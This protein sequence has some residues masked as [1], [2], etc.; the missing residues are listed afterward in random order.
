MNLSADEVDGPDDIRAFFDEIYERGWTDGLPVIP[1][2]ADY[3]NEMLEANCV[4]PDEI[5]GHVAPDSAPATMEKI[6]INAVM[7]GCRNEYMPVLIAAVRAIV[8]PKFNL[9]GIQGTTNS[10]TPF[11]VVNGPVRAR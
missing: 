3:V 9:M 10:V 8:E 1:P 4:R 11:F 7:A 2:R 6:A 5:V